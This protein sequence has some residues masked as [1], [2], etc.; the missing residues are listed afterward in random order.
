MVFQTRWLLVLS[1]WLTGPEAT[2][3]RRPRASPPLFPPLMRGAPRPP[4][5]VS[6]T[7]LAAFTQAVLYLLRYS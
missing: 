6:P 5:L 2:L 7:S 1:S 4:I 3:D